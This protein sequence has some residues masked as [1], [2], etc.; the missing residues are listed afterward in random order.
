MAIPGLQANVGVY[1]SQLGEYFTKSKKLDVANGLLGHNYHFAEMLHLN[2][3]KVD[4][5]D[6]C[7]F[8]TLLAEAGAAGPQAAF[9]TREVKAGDGMKRGNVSWSFFE[10]SWAMAEEEK[11]MGEGPFKIYDLM[12]ARQDAATMKAANQLEGLHMAQDGNLAQLSAEKPPAPG[13]KYWIT[14]LG[15]AADGTTMVGGLDSSAFDRRWTNYYAGPLGSNLNKTQTHSTASNDKLVSAN[16]LLQYFKRVFRLLHFKNP[17]GM[18]TKLAGKAAERM[19]G[20]KI[21]VDE[22]CWE[23]WEALLEA[24]NS[25]DNLTN[26]ESASGE[27]AFRGVPLEWAEQLGLDSSGLPASCAHAD[28]GSGALTTGQY[29]N[30]GEALFYNTD[31]LRIICH[32]DKAPERKPLEWLPAQQCIWQLWKLWYSVVCRQRRATCYLWGF[33]PLKT[34]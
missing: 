6:T 17:K 26:K 11:G 2:P 18:P 27:P 15:R 31:D 13:L 22:I 7:Y 32:E 29:A 16:Q 25:A 28:F 1:N 5:G 23:A 20:Q 9:A 4:G 24:K 21:L 34:R 12:E 14:R 30:T 3:I 8:D 19:K 33:S 10:W